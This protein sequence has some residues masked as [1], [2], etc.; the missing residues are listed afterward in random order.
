MDKCSQGM[1]EVVVLNRKGMKDT[2][3]D[4]NLVQGV[5]RVRGIGSFREGWPLQTLRVESCL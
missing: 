3:R 1:D 2:G 5:V 4:L